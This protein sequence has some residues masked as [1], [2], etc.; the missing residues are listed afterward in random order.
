MNPPPSDPNEEPAGPEGILVV[1]DKPANLIAAKSALEALGARVVCA[2]SGEAA[3]RLLLQD[4]FALVLL[5]VN[6]PLMDGF[7]VAR[8]IRARIRSRRTPIIFITAYGR[9]EQDVLAAYELGAVDFLFKPFAPE[10]LRA[11]AS[12]FIDLARQEN[13]IREHERREHTRA[14]E[15]AR[16]TWQDEALLQQRDQLAELDRRKNQFLAVLG[17]EL[18]NP[19]AP[20]TAGLEL[21]RQ[22]IARDSRIDPGFSRT[23]DAM[24]RHVEHLTRLVDDLF[25]ISRINSGKVELQMATV[26]IQDVVAQAVAISRPSLEEEGQEL[27]LEAGNERLVMQG[28]LVRLVQVVANLLNNAARYS[29][30]GGRICVGCLRIRDQI[31]IRVKDSGQGISPAVLPRIFDAFVQ[32]EE[33]PS[34]GLGLGL[35][36]VHQLVTRHRGTV[37]AHSEGVGRGT[38]FVVRLPLDVDA[39]EARA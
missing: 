4:E 10:I 35:T 3:L 29:P 27:V 15:L 6:M 28:D 37:S 33:H 7:E 26:C 18:R 38:E 13:Q 14:L 20:L 23:R 8:M 17:H 34:A 19:L 11:K 31:E 21:L 12:V 36:I 32:Q 2:E 30:R 24:H 9:E 1:D 25:D 5:D 22:L 39:M 16:K